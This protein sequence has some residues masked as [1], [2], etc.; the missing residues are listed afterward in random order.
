MITSL[1]K[2]HQSHLCM[3]WIDNKKAF[4]SLPHTWIVTV[5]EMY[6]ICPTIRKFVEALMK[7]RKT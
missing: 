7:R 2:I 4:D 6:R 3:T 1:A 5:M